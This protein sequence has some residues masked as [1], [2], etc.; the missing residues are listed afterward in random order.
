MYT[1]P[2]HCGLLPGTFRQYLLDNHVIEERAIAIKELGEADKIY[3]INSVRKW[4]E[5]ELTQ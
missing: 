2:L 4:I 3:L 5:V 1:P